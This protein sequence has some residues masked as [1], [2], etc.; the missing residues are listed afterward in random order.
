MDVAH[1]REVVAFGACE[2]PLVLD[3]ALRDWPS[4][5]CAVVVMHDEVFGPQRVVV[6]P[7]VQ[8]AAVAT[9][10]NRCTCLVV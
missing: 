4:T 2:H 10:L 9:K 7:D 1:P 3:D 6:Y 5:S 8:R